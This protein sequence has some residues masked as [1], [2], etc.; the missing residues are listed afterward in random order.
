MG[1]AAKT[2]NSRVKIKGQQQNSREQQSLFQE[3]GITEIDLQTKQT[4]D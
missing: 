4:K 2:A 1:K 3:Y